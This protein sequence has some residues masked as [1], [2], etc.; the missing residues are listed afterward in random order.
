VGRGRANY[1]RAAVIGLLLAASHVPASDEETRT[2]ERLEALVGEIRALGEELRNDKQER[3]NLREALRRSEVA[4]G[5]LQK[6]IRRTRDNLEEIRNELHDLE[7]RRAELEVA[8]GEQQEVISRDIQTAYQL[9]RQGQM[10]VLLNQERPDTLARAMAY[11]EYF[12]EA[13]NTRIDRYLEVMRDIDA[14]EPE[15]RQTATQLEITRERLDEQ[16]LVLVDQKAQRQRDLDALNAAIASKDAALQKLDADREELERVLEVLTEAIAELEVPADYR[17]FAALRGNMPRPVAGKPSNRFGRRRGDSQ[18]RWQGLVI[19]AREGVTVQA[20]HHGRVVFADWLR[21][22]GL[23]LI[24]DHGAGYM[25]LYAHN[26]TLLR[27][28]GEW[29]SAGAPVATVGNTGGQQEAA[30]Y[31]EIRANG[32]PTDPGPWLRSG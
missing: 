8:R 19:P 4:I 25:S 22:S 17:D 15:I 32:K 21:G 5:N 18:M 14:I 9:G 10:K 20:I 23:L 7:A 16:R 1:F 30:L 12:F 6:D 31:F 27:E 24:I 11:Y 3:G 26:Q 2:R 13:R 28:V 29:V